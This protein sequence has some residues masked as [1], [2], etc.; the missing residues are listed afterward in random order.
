MHK[1][2]YCGAHRYHLVIGHFELPSTNVVNVTND[3]T[4]YDSRHFQARL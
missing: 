4:D 1:I 2:G 3:Y